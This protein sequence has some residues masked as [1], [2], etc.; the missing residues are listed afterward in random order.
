MREIRAKESSIAN[1]PFR[2][3][4]DLSKKE[5]SLV[6][7]LWDKNLGFVNLLLFLVAYGLVWLVGNAW[8][9]GS[10]LAILMYC[11][12]EVRLIWV[13]YLARKI[14]GR[15]FCETAPIQRELDKKGRIYLSLFFGTAFKGLIF[16]TL[17]SVGLVGGVWFLIGFTYMNLQVDDL[18]F[19]RGMRCLKEGCPIRKVSIMCH[20]CKILDDD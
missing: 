2:L 4:L 8:N 19:E 1:P 15:Y 9:Y 18:T 14:N 13:N 20:N 3:V 16:L 17:F 11:W 5:E 12:F 10:V 6:S 7:F